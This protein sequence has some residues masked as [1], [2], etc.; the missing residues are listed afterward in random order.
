MGLSWDVLEAH[1]AVLRPSWV[2][3]ADRSATR[4]SLGP[5]WGPLGAL[6]AVLEGSEG[7]LRPVEQ[8][9]GAPGNSRELPEIAKNP[10]K[11]PGR[12]KNPQESPGKPRVRAPKKLSAPLPLRAA[13]LHEPWGTPLRAEGTV[14]DI[15][16]GG[17]TN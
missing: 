11:S 9:P 15:K 8:L 3:W 2:S 10:R 1:W 4:G 7:R 12:G 13:E 5:S 14:A 17:A 6:L 16:E